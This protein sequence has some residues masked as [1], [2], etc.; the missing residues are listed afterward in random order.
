MAIWG[1]VG[2]ARTRTNRNPAPAHRTL[3]AAQ[4]NVI[5]GSTPE[6]ASNRVIDFRNCTIVLEREMVVPQGT[7]NCTLDF[8]G[9][10]IFC[11][12]NT[13]PNYPH[14]AG[15]FMLRVGAE[16][17]QYELS[18]TNLREDNASE[19]FNV[20]GGVQ[21]G[22]SSCVATGNPPAGT[23]MLVSKD[24]LDDIFWAM[25]PHAPRNP[26]RLFIRVTS[27][28][29]NNVA[30][31]R[32]VPMG[33]PIAQ[34]RLLER[35]NG[36]LVVGMSRTV[37]RNITIMGGTWD[38]RENGH[39]TPSVNH[40]V[41]V[42]IGVHVFDGLVIRN[43]NVAYANV[44]I[45]M[46][47]G[48]NL[49][50]TNC[51][52]GPLGN[53]I[54]TQFGITTN[55]NRG[56]WYGVV[57]QGTENSYISRIRTL[58]NDAINVGCRATLVTGAHCNAV[59]E[60]CEGFGTGNAASQLFI[61]NYIDVTH[62]QGGW[63][64]MTRRC[65]ADLLNI[66]N[67]GWLGGN[68]ENAVVEDC[69]FS[70]IASQAGTRDV[71][72][73]GV[74]PV[75]Q[76]TCDTLML[77]AVMQSYNGDH[78]AGLELGTE[79][80]TF[81]NAV[82]GSVA[83]GAGHSN[84]RN[85]DVA[86]GPP[87]GPS[88]HPEMMFSV[89]ENV[90]FNNTEF[91]DRQTSLV[92]MNTVG[93]WRGDG[94]IRLGGAVRVPGNLTFNNCTFTVN[95]T[96]R[97][98]P[99]IEINHRHPTRP[100]PM[101]LRFNGCTFSNPDLPI[102]RTRND[103]IVNVTPPSFLHSGTGIHNSSGV[104][105]GTSFRTGY[106][107]DSQSRRPFAAYSLRRLNGNYRG[108]IVRLAF[109]NGATLLGTE[110][111]FG[112]QNTTTRQLI[113]NSLNAPDAIRNNNLNQ[114][115]ENISDSGSPTSWITDRY[116]TATEVRVPMWYD[117]SGNERHLVQP[118]FANQPVF[119]PDGWRTGDASI[120]FPVGALNRFFILPQTVN[121]QGNGLSYAAAWSHDV[122]NTVTPEL[123]RGT[124]FS[125]TRH[126][127]PGVVGL[128]DAHWAV[129]WRTDT[130]Q[131]YHLRIE[132]RNPAGTANGDWRYFPHMPIGDTATRCVNFMAY[133]DHLPFSGHAGSASSAQMT[134]NSNLGL[135]INEGS[136][137]GYANRT[138]IKND[139]N[140]TV[141]AAIHPLV[142][143][144]RHLQGKISELIIWDS[145]NPHG[146]AAAMRD[147]SLV[148]RDSVM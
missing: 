43:C 137:G 8:R 9:S 132:S 125:F 98:R 87:V 5:I 53:N 50:L 27:N 33:F 101:N 21:K 71:I 61:G 67:P 4:A 56:Q 20:I 129:F 55:G 39:T 124:L 91:R 52:L 82:I 117:Q 122:H 32:P 83:D 103:A 90:T 63:N 112:D 45:S 38:G 116:P 22:A 133:G 105:T 17:G 148:W 60:E 35:D 70:T 97:N 111:V 62:G 113:V 1:R 142:S 130:N 135:G 93:Y 143:T 69:F 134:N 6:A 19:G 47:A 115:G 3:T 15:S 2:S 7:H 44:G 104:P 80:L 74:H 48:R 57:N 73:R 123:A 126:A 107:L 46:K 49:R 30:F 120:M 36:G 102:V 96:L 127:R 128:G 54:P 68:G 109:Y 41:G 51:V 140:M 31:D 144:P 108:P 77:G 78:R 131:N 66:T 26:R 79:S 12:T 14:N 146:A 34:L 118:T 94:L 85:P 147:M 88:N 58:K 114:V 18:M 92:N 64:L 86:F 65:A 75:R 59:V 11:G 95:S 89:L 138:F 121:L 145:F 136:S 81:E 23:Y 76:R 25:T 139:L 72:V 29:S 100:Q 119:S 24:P 42:G 10:R 28:N 84:A 40:C 13:G 37:C 16:R 106:L 99:Y 141:G 110:D